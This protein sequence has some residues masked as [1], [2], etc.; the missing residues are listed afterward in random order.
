VPLDSATLSH[1][2]RIGP[3]AR[4]L[5]GSWQGWR[6]AHLHLDGSVGAADPGT[7]LTPAA[8]ERR[9]PSIAGLVHP[10]ELSQVPLLEEERTPQRHLFPQGRLD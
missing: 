6:G 9:L 5:L 1:P 8:F 2:D 3:P 7:A 4:Q 10:A